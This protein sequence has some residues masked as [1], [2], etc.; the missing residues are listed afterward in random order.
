ML[1]ERPKSARQCMSQPFFPTAEHL[2]LFQDRTRT[3]PGHCPP[4]LVRRR[5]ARTLPDAASVLRDSARVAPELERHL[6]PTG[7]VGSGQPVFV[8]R[9]D[10]PGYLEID[11]TENRKRAVGNSYSDSSPEVAR[12]FP[13]IHS[14]LL[15]GRAGRPPRNLPEKRSDFLVMF[16]W[17]TESQQNTSCRSDRT[18]TPAPARNALTQTSVSFKVRCQ[19]SLLRQAS[20]QAGPLRCR[21][22]GGCRRPFRVTAM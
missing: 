2:K 6:S 10:C 14:S 22:T 16:R 20:R 9:K 5:R 8:D 12:T 18:M 15:T 11:P 13:G 21:L 19:A 17:S 4:D 3:I 1:S 7:H